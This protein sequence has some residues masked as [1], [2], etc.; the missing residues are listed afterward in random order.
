MTRIISLTLFVLLFSISSF[1]QENKL[2]VQELTDQFYMIS[3]G[4]GNMLLYNH[5]QS[6]M[7][8]DDSFAPN[9]PELQAI[10]MEKCE[11]SIKYLINT[12]WHPDHVSGNVEFGQLNDITIVAHEAVRKRMKDGSYIEFFKNEVAPADKQALPDLTFDSALTFHLDETQI[13]LIHFE[14]AHTDGDIVVHFPE[15]NVMH[16]G[17][18]YFQGQ[19][20][21]LDHSSGGTYLGLIQALRA[22]LPMINDETILV[23]GHGQA[24]N[25]EE[26]KAYLKMVEQVFAIVGK[27]NSEGKS[28]EE[29][30][31]SEMMLQL[32]KVWNKGFITNVTITEL[33]LKDF[34]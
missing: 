28:A 17:D 20:P 12:H 7:L 8:I 1:A 22:I 21:Y 25:Q 26:L 31:N 30:A 11:D 19:F 24:S 16:M 5:P 34:E 14:H 33:M 27:M 10:I 6:P 18:L 15:H 13:E 29:I 9:Y 3:G 4:G 23:P 2:T 32:D